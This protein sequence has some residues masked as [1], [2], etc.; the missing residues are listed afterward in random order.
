MKTGLA[1]YEINVNT[2]I[3]PDIDLQQGDITNTI[4]IK[5]MMTP[6]PID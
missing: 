1:D 5:Q 2:F 4:Y 6:I 3:Q